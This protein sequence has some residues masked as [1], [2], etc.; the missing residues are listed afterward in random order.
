MT[1]NAT[2]NTRNFRITTVEKTITVADEQLSQLWA[3]WQATAERSSRERA[4]WERI[5]DRAAVL[6]EVEE[7]NIDFVMDVNKV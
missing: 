3:E 1:T 6:A 5:T 4:A 7:S 2:T